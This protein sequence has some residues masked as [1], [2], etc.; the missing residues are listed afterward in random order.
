M[1]GT[2][3]K[4]NSNENIIDE[5]IA[6]KS[7]F[8]T[9]GFSVFLVS[10]LLFFILE[11]FTSSKISTQ[12]AILKKGGGAE[13]K[14]REIL[15]QIALKGKDVKDLEYKYIKEIMQFMSPT[16]FQEF[17]N[18]ISTLA[19][20]LNVQINSLN[21]IESKKLDIYEI[22]AIEYEFLSKYEN[23][24][25]LKS[26]LSETNFK[27]N[28]VE[29]TIQRYS[30]KS[31]K[32]LANGIIHAYVFENKEDLLKKNE[33]LIEQQKIIEEKEAKKKASSKN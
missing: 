28:L 17:K 5:T 22:Y 10:I 19:N 31:D 7:K 9:V 12:N 23:F 18:S 16:E 2:K 13:E 32:I 26:K 29:E 3:K 33:K 30:P 6:D 11:I 8:V 1:F 21:E 4:A 15:M 27:I 25:Q 24:I 14:S 20:P